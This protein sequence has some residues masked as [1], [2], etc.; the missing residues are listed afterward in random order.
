MGRLLSRAIAVCFVCLFIVIAAVSTWMAA[1]RGSLTDV[2]TYKQTLI[3]QN[4]YQDL[5]PYVIPSILEE[6]QDDLSEDANF[7]IDLNDIDQ[8]MTVGNWRDVA[9]ELIPAQW[10][11]TQTE[12]L[13]D[14]ID[15]IKQGDI[16]QREDVIDLSEIIERLQGASGERASTIIIN[17]APDCTLQQAAQ[18]RQLNSNR[19]TVFP[20]CKPSAQLESVSKSA[21]TGWFTAIGSQLELAQGNT[22]RLSIPENAANFI[23]QIFQL[24]AQLSLLLLLCPLSLIGIII[25]FAVRNTQSFG[26]WLG[27][28]FILAGITT[29]FLIFSS[30]IPV[31]A[32]FDDI[33]NASND[34]AR[35]QAQISAG[36]LRSVYTGAS[37]T[38]IAYAGGMIIGGFILLVISF[39]GRSHNYLVPEGSVLVGEDGRVISTTQPQRKT[40]PLPKDEA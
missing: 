2:E 9:N 35:F 25:F 39:V 7:Q 1:F 6:S 19:G 10:L 26:R 32:S 8:V 28:S 31:F 5:I 22:N 40:V 21:I 12:S 17:A 30:Q 27:W 38:M 23:F 36:F 24:D 29:L 37:E 18:L 4:V 13:L 33:F 11:Q 34:G 20:I 15:A 3:E 16:R 14:S